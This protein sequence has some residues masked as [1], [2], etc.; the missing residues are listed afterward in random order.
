MRHGGNAGNLRSSGTTPKW[1][2]R[3]P[4]ARVPD[5]WPDS[6]LALMILL[7]KPYYPSPH[8]RLDRPLSSTR[9]RVIPLCNEP[10]RRKTPKTAMK[11]PSSRVP[12]PWPVLDSVEPVFFWEH[13]PSSFQRCQHRS[14]PPTRSRVIPLSI[15]PPNGSSLAD[16]IMQASWNILR[17]ANVLTPLSQSESPIEVGAPYDSSRWRN[18]NWPIRSLGSPR[19]NDVTPTWRPLIG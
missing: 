2:F 1:L 16:F 7:R 12:D 17:G 4:L 9:S 18:L 10:P 11:A 6:N 14:P 3:A 19:V 8:W 13:F 15:R 5:P